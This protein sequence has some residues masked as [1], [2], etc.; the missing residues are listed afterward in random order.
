MRMRVRVGVGV[1]GGG[2]RRTSAPAVAHHCV[3]A[4][5]ARLAS[6]LCRCRR[7]AAPASRRRA[8]P[9]S[10]RRVAPASRRRAASASPRRAAPASRRRSAQAGM[11]VRRGEADV[12]AGAMYLNGMYY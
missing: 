9:A 3:P 8:T 5:P 1:R 4:W 12:M 10:R 11:P 6:L 2:A 7:R